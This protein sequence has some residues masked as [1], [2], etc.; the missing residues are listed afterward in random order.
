MKPARRKRMLVVL[1]VLIGGGALSAGLFALAGDSVNVWRDPTDVLAINAAQTQLMLGGL[2]VEGS[3]Q[4]GE[5]L[6]V[7]FAVTDSKSQ[8]MVE[9][10]GIL[11]DLFAEG[12]GVMAEG[13]WNGDTLQ[14]TRV[15][16][17]HDEN[18]TA[19]QIE[20]S[21]AKRAG[22]NYRSKNSE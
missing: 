20:S 16:A 1:T 12:A 5:N 11:P 7:S 18:Y 15:L 9:Y 3:V 8:V 22:E 19:P 6:A 14:A 10:R 13:I 21:L 4:H 17:R 2:V